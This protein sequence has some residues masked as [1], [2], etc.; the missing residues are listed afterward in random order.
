MRMVQALVY[1][2]AV[3]VTTSMGI[4]L[5]SSGE[6]G[7]R[8]ALP[9][10]TIHMH[11]AGGGAQGYTEDVRIAYHEQERMEKPLFTIVG[12]NTGHS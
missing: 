4:V 1:T 8:Y 9:H 7:H 10:A 3:G 12:K 2:T 5:L 6:K 11:P